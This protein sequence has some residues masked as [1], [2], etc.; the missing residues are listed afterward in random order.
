METSNK[1]LDS[2]GIV[3]K[4]SKITPSGNLIT[5]TTIR[6]H[7]EG[8]CDINLLLILISISF[9]MRGNAYMY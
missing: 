6:R 1:P 2:S 5:T 8:A 9:V 7:D 3:E 4:T